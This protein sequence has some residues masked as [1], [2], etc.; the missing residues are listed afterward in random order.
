MKR[1]NFRIETENGIEY[2]CHFSENEEAAWKE[3]DEK[4]PDQ[5]KWKNVE[6]FDFISDA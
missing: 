6:M 1:Y 3:L 4:F 5:T 2:R